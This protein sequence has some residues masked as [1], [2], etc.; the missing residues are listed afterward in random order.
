VEP[1]GDV[2]LTT[3][4]EPG[5]RWDIHGIAL[6]PGGDACAL[7]RRAGRPVVK[8]PADF[9]G[10]T[11]GYELLA[12]RLIRGHAGLGAPRPAI[13]VPL[14]GKIVSAIGLADV[15]LVR[16]GEAG[17]APLPG[18]ETGGAAGLAWA[19]GYVVVP[20]MREGFAAGDLV[21]VHR[22]AP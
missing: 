9:L 2:T 3:R 19:D 20:A 13:E 11:V 1:K 15:V 10:F 22:F 18:I 5:D 6:R 16:L 8:L 7:G 17:A 12:A 4:A 21:R 14:A